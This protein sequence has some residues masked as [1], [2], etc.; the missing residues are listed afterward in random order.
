MSPNPRAPIR[1]VERAV[2]AHAHQAFLDG[3]RPAKVADVVIL[4]IVNGADRVGRPLGN[5]IVHT[6]DE[7]PMGFFAERVAKLEPS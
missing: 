6:V 7:L 3:T 1:V 4:A 5:V 2:A